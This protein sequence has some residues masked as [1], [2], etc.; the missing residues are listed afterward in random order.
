MRRC[1]VLVSLALGFS[2]CGAAS[3]QPTNS[4]I[5]GRIVAGPTCPV[6]TIP[7]QPSCAPHPLTATLSVH[8]VGST[9]AQHVRSGPDGH[10]R[11]HLPPAT[12]V[13]QPLTPNGSPFPRPPSPLT[14]K[15]RPNHFTTITITYDTGIR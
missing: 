14:L 13:V 7:P 6:E 8:A 9:T 2:A 10:F 1:V 3:G 12:Y 15:V 11:I 4:G 5:S